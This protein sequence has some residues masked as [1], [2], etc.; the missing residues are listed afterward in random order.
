MAEVLKLTQFLEANGKAQM[1]VGRCGVDPEFDVQGAAE[2][3][4]G[5]KFCL[6]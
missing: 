1:N 6:R 5:E 3:E 2:A 4:F